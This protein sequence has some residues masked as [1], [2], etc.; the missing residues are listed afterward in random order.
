M[1]AVGGRVEKLRLVLGV[2]RH[3]DDLLDVKPQ[4]DAKPVAV[5]LEQLR[6]RDRRREIFRVAIVV[7]HQRHRFF[8]ADA[9]H[10]HRPDPVMDE[11]VG[12]VD[13]LR[14]VARLQPLDDDARLLQAPQHFGVPVL[15][16][17]IDPEKVGGSRHFGVDTLFGQPGVPVEG[18]RGRGRQPG[19]GERGRGAGQQAEEERQFSSH[20]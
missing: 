12:H 14:S 20:Q 1:R 13:L 7:L 9:R 16:Q 10:E 17:R 11:A 15:R 2:H 6:A 5:A 4:R 3:G 8:D 19:G 18:R